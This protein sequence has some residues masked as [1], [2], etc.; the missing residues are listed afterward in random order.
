MDQIMEET[1]FHEKRKI[2]KIK[3]EEFPLLSLQI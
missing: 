3:R 1:E 2:Q